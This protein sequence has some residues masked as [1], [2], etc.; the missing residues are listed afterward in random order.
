MRSVLV[1]GKEMKTTLIIVAGLASLIIAGC[2]S[3]K[4]GG[5]SA[6][7][8]F[9]LDTPFFTT[10][11]TQGDRKTVTVS[12]DR[13]KYFKEDV[14]L[15]AESSPGISVDPTDVLVRADESADVQFQISAA[16]D[17]ALGEYIVRVKGTP[18]TGQ[19][20]S[21]EIKVKVVSP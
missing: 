12:V 11:I 13:D 15:Q 21:T 16:E 10:N 6:D 14:R 17:A 1:K 8:G 20:T 5:L 2:G 19:S 18:E 9:R 3:P 7:E 4:G